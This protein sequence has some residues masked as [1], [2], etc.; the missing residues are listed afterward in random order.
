M[1]D[2]FN[3]Q[4]VSWHLDDSGVNETVVVHS[5]GRR[6]SGESVALRI[7]GF[8]PSFHIKISERISSS[9]CYSQLHDLVQKRLWKLGKHLRTDADAVHAK[10]L[11]GFTRDTSPFFKLSFKNLQAYGRAKWLFTCIHRDR[12]DVAEAQK[13][14]TDYKMRKIALEDELEDEPDK[15]AKWERRRKLV[16]SYCNEKALETGTNESTIE[17]IIDLGEASAPFEFASI[18][19]FN[20]IDPTLQFLHE[21]KLK[22]AGWIAVDSGYSVDHLQKITTCDIEMQVAIERI[23]HHECMTICGKLKEMSFDIECYSLGTHIASG[24]KETD[25]VFQI[26][27]TVKTYSDPTT[28]KYLFHLRTPE[29]MRGPGMTGRCGEIPGATVVNCETETELLLTWR[30]FVLDQDPDFFEGYNIDNFDWSYL[31]DRAEIFGCTAE[32][33]LLSRLK[34]FKCTAEDNTFSSA[35]RGEK[36]YRR[37]YTPGRV[38]VDVMGW[39]QVNVPPSRYETW[40]L[41]IVAQKEI[42]ETKDD[43]PYETA[44]LAWEAGDETILTKVG[45]YCIQDCVLPQKI[46]NKMDILTQCFEMANITITPINMILTR[47]QQIKVFSLICFMCLQLGFMVPVMDARGDESFEGATVVDPTRG[48]H[49]DPT[50]TLDFESLYPS[51]FRAF[52]ICYS[53]LVRDPTLH[54]KLME[55]AGPEKKVDVS[56]DG[57]DYAV[58][59]W[60]EKTYIEHS[61]KHGER[62]F[63]SVQDAASMTKAKV[64]DIEAGQIGS[65]AS[66]KSGKQSLP[67]WR[68]GVRTHSFSYAQ[69]QTCVLPTFLKDILDQRRA[70]KKMMG[71]IESSQDPEDKLRYRVLNGRQLAL[72][73]TANSVYG[74]PGAFMLN[75]IALG[76]S[77]TSVGRRLNKET[78]DFCTHELESILRSRFWDQRDCSTFLDDKLKVVIDESIVETPPGWTKKFPTSSL[79]RPWLEGNVHFEVIGGDTGKHIL[80]SFSHMH[81]C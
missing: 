62:I 59:Q 11:W 6:E 38:S 47:G 20:I 69:N 41:G 72:K 76:S 7:K 52:Q 12:I 36:K 68:H 58:I 28:S 56:H 44:R 73:V 17:W 77:V 30:Q 23:R 64:A 29:N 39:L 70:V 25:C 31:M 24:K 1:Q 32:F 13:L 48:L 55:L 34:Q 43:M 67:Y 5:F 78:V 80:S 81:L 3:F 9:S 74:F 57:I 26:G 61:V 33:G 10:S 4:A 49:F 37:V 54:G 53:T 46:S 50:M 22:P 65:S 71:Q 16:R 21:T 75:E 40:G 2:Q 66:A 51:I 45:E 63:H 19:L 79:G 15:S 8:E 18:S 35:A 60:T 27:A 42:G 14:Y